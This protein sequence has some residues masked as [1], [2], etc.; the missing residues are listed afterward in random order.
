MHVLD[1]DETLYSIQLLGCAGCFVIYS[2]RKET[3]KN[4]EA[5][6]INMAFSVRLTLRLSHYMSAL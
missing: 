5:I 3:N 1:G 6:N 2:S 4:Y